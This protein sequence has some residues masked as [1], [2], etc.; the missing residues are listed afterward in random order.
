MYVSVG[1]V[2]S[3]CDTMPANFYAVANDY[4]RTP[5]GREKLP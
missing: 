1:L 2:K 5:F 3:A 4:K